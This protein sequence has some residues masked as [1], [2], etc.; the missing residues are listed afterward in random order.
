MGAA[1][2]VDLL[3]AIIGAGLVVV[4]LWEVF[5]DLFRPGGTG[6]LSDWIG[7]RLFTL[8]KRYHRELS[9][10]GP[11]ALVS[12]V[13]VWVAG[14]VLGFALLYWRPYPQAF[15]TSTGEVPTS[16]SHFLPVLYF[17]FETLVTLGYGDL[18]PR[19]GVV[20]GLSTVE[21]L[22][23]F[24]LLTASVSA[25]VL[26]YPA[27]SRMRLLGRGV[28]H[29]VAAEAETG[30][31]LASSGSDLV[32]NQLARDV[33]RAGIDLVHFPIVY[34]FAAKEP[35]AS[36]ARWAAAIARLASG[37]RAAT[38]RAHVRL[39]GAAL[40]HAL[41]EFAAILD[42]RF[43]TTHE[44]DRRRIFDAFARDHLIAA[45]PARS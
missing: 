14:L 12:V 6:A 16:S 1:R 38:C 3:A 17:S 35:D 9:L 22:V 8:F 45:A 28:A 29:I 21:A 19:T 43:L 42:E 24:G 25:I 33:T 41:D 40:D 4:I 27:L 32:L 31:S 5:N 15:L 23:G 2:S 11:V 18:V 30:A 37:A 36:V 20:R 26:L 44:R 10:A 13:A 34:Y 7:R 39:A